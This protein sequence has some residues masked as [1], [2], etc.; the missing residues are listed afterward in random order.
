MVS[1][2]LGKPRYLSDL[3]LAVIGMLKKARVSTTTI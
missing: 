1:K 3:D 2:M